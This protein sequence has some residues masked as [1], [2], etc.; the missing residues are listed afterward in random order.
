MK[1]LLLLLMLFALGLAPMLAQDATEDTTLTI[2]LTG[3]LSKISGLD[4]LGVNGES[5]TAS[6]MIGESATPSSSTS[7]SA[8]YTIPAGGVSTTVGAITFTNTKP[9]TMKV[10]LAATHDILAIQGPGP[11]GSQIKVTSTLKKGSWTSAVLLHPAPF[12]PSP[13]RPSP[14]NSRLQYTVPALCNVATVLA[15][16]GHISNSAATS[17]L[18]ADD[19]S[20]Q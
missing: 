7:D 17:E 10:T 2:T 14:S 16:T 3:T 12:S 9:W 6:A 4:C 19:D 8:T 15:V 11:A 1:R 18:P 20:D 13:Q 5:A